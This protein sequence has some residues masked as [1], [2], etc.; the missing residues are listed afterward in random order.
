MEKLL[1]ELLDA[2]GEIAREHGE[3]YD[4]QDEL[5]EAIHF[6]YLKPVE[7]YALPSDY[8]LDSAAA[9]QQ[10]REALEQYVTATKAKAEELKLDFHGRLDAFQNPYAAAKDHTYDDFFGSTPPN[11]F[12]ASGEWIGLR[13]E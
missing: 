12:D 2:L 4:C 3:L 6:A 9:N 11:F 10:V 5:R 7:G 13:G 8:G 1:A